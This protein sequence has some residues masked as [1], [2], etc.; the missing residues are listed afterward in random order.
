MKTIALVI[1]DR[2]GFVS[3]RDADGK[4]ILHGKYSSKLT[5]KIEQ[6][7]NEDT[8][9]LVSPEYIESIKSSQI[10]KLLNEA[11]IQQHENTN[12]R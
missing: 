12:I 5:I 2:N 9:W 1:I 11:K 8:K 10:K 4:T 3:C 6:N 7:S